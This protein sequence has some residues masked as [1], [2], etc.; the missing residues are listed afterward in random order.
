MILQATNISAFDAD[1]VGLLGVT[2]KGETSACCKNISPYFIAN[3]IFSLEFFFAIII[4]IQKKTIF[5]FIM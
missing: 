4:L 5:I 3:S 2:F 1:N